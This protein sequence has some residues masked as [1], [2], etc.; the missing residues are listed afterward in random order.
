MYKFRSMKY[1]AEDELVNLK[2]NNES[3]EVMFKMKNDPRVTKVGAFLRKHSLDELPQLFNVLKG[4]MSLIGPRPPLVSELKNYKNWHYKRFATLP[5]MTG[6]W[7][8][9]GRSSILDFDKV[10]RLDVQYIEN[11]NLFFDFGILLKTV[12]VVIRG[13]E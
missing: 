2:K 9:S 4:E 11:W 10:V 1:G 6:L 5:G 12:P 13:D 3:N 7:Q 8:V